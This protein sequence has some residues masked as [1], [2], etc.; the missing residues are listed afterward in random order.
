[1]RIAW[2]N[3]ED[4]QQA[5]QT[6]RR[7]IRDAI[8]QRAPPNQ[9]PATINYQRQEAKAEATRAWEERWH[10]NPRTSL[11]Y[12]TACTKPP[13]GRIHPILRIQQKGWEDKPFRSRR[14]GTLHRAK[15]SRAT[16]SN[17]F[18]FITGH[19]FTGGYTA[20]FLGKK[21]P[22]PL[23]EELVACPCGELPQTVEHV[24]LGSPI[25]DTARRKHLITCGRTRV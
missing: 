23:P 7:L 21:L 11:A 2:F 17:L 12:H 5:Y 4:A 24:L 9:T 15:V 6:T 14:K 20:R 10:E 1:M 25:H 8:K 13:D 3:Q 22:G 16:T 18:R 19:A